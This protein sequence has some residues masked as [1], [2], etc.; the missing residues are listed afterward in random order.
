MILDAHRGIKVYPPSEIFGKLV[1][2]NAIKHQKGVPSHPNFSQPFYTLPPKFRQKPHRPSPWNFKPWA[3]MTL[4][5]FLYLT[6]QAF[7]KV[8][9]H[10]SF[11]KAAIFIFYFKTFCSFLI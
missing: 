2:K 5:P 8:L 10:T 9:F 1:N 3:S 6:N 7:V 4:S 11:N